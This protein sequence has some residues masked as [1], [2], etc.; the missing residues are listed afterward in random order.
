M[1]LAGLAL[2]AMCISLIQEQA[3]RAAGAAM[4]VTNELEE[5]DLV[6][7]TLRRANFGSEDAPG[8]IEAAGA[9]VSAL[10]GAVSPE[11]SS[12]EEE[13]EEEEENSADEEAAAKPESSE[14][15]SSD[16][17]EDDDGTSDDE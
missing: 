16:D 4:G 7:I 10:P 9:G 15:P 8:D 11:E 6:E 1:L 3:A 17:S 12:E 2:I 14:G 13:E 5:L